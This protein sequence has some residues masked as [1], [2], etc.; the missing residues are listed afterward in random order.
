MP[1]P[2]P[3]TRSCSCQF[4]LSL[5]PLAPVPAHMYVE[6]AEYSIALE[7]SRIWGRPERTQEVKEAIRVS[8]MYNVALGVFLYVGSSVLVSVLTVN[9]DRRMTDIVIGTSRV[10]AGIVFFVLSVNIAQWYGV[11]FMAKRRVATFRTLKEVKFNFSWSL[12]KQMSATF[13][14]N[15][16]FSCRTEQ[17]ANLYGVLGMSRL[18]SFRFFPP[19]GVARWHLRFC[20]S[21]LGCLPSCPPILSCLLCVPFSWGPHRCPHHLFGLPVPSRMQGPEEEGCHFYCPHSAD[22]ELLLRR[23][24][25][26]VHR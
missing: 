23:L 2:R 15:L 19:A 24:W 11:Y 5:S 21:L 22:S 9:M 10:F 6:F 20:S 17:L 13:F 8:F 14:Y 1:P 18:V 7:R 26:C 4:C 16:F 12:W 25:D 3:L